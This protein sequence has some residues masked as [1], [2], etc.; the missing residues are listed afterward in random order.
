MSEPRI[1]VTGGTGFAG[2]F[3]VEEL[4]AQGQSDVHVTSFS[5]L[6]KEWFLPSDHVHVVDLSQA[7]SV[8]H[9]IQTLQPTQIYHL[10]ALSEVGS[11]FN[12]AGKIITNN[13]LLQINLL[14]A[15]RDHCPSTRLVVVGSAQEYDIHQPIPATG[16]NEQHPLGP[17]NP[18]A[19]SKVTQ[20]LI[21]LSYHYSYK[22]DIVIARP[23][24][25]TGERQQPAF[26]IP[27]FAQQIVLVERGRQ[28]EIKIGNL[29]AVRDFTDVKDVVKAYILLMDRGS[30]GQA[31][32]IGSGQG[33][34]MKEILTI[35][36]SLAKQEI[37]VVT[38][39]SKLRP[40]DSPSVIADISKIAALGW[41][42]TVPLESTLE[43]VI[44]YWREH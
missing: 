9:L 27:S 7:D 42:P 2:S 28:P 21:A 12:Q 8:I 40:H 25:H 6:T 39:P 20:D 24:N 18:Y 32:N 36:L 38:D 15:V 31:Y 26:A 37:R 29:D 14:D 19:V 11:S 43:R 16:I 1:L 34:S 30:A 3:L 35:L 10:A 4:L 5:P 33:V 44:E 41:Q 22:L 13:A 17:A 23:F